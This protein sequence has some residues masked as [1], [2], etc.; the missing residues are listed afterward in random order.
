MFDDQVW[1]LILTAIFQLALS[2]PGLG[3]YVACG[4]FTVA[5]IIIVVGIVLSLTKSWVRST[6]EDEEVL[7]D[8]MN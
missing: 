3:F 8:N 1:L 2:L 7:T 4:L 6:Q 5:V